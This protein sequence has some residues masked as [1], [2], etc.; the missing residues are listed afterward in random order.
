MVDIIPDAKVLI[1]QFGAFLIVLLVLRAFMFKPLMQIIQ[2]RQE[3]IAGQ[4]ENV[5]KTLKEADELKKQYN[6]RLASV[7][8]EL[9]EKIAS[10]IKEGHD[11]KEQILEESRRHADEIILRAQEEIKRETEVAMVNLKNTVAE[12]A[13]DAA[14]KVIAA[15]LDI[16]KHKKLIDDFIENIDEVKK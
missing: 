6:E 14:E 4:Y 5:D 15:E 8:D 12:L 11:M 3:E 16:E 13:V 9:K 10:A 1:L 2:T 7:D